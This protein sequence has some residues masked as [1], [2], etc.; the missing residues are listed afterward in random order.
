M[1]VADILCMTVECLHFLASLNVM[2]TIPMQYSAKHEYRTELP[3]RGNETW[4]L[5]NKMKRLQHLATYN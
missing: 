2:P 5:E 4:P 3:V 1:D